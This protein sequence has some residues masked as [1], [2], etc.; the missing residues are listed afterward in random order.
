M[1]KINAFILAAGQGER[2]R[3]ITNHIPK[4]L[5]PILGKPV[6]QRVLENLISIDVNMVGINLHF[7]KELIREWVES[8]GF[9]EN[10]TIFTEEDALG[11]GG[12]LKNA[13]QLLKDS[14]FIL[15]N[16]DI[17]SDIDLEGL[18][19]Y[20][21]ASENLVT[22]AVHDHPEFNNVAIDNAGYLKSVGDPKTSGPGE[23][24]AVAY[25]GVSVYD[26]N[27]LNILPEGQS[28]LVDGWFQAIRGG[29]H[30]GTFDVIGS[31]WND[32]GTPSRYA[33]ALFEMLNN[34]GETV[35]LHTSAKGCGD[36]ETD[37]FIV[38]EDGSYFGSG[39]FLKNSI[40]LPGGRA[41]EDSHYE[42]Y[43]LGNG[44]KINLSEDKMPESNED[45]ILIGTGGSDRNYYRVKND[46]GSAVLMV[47][48]EDDS[49]FNRHIEYSRF[50]KDS[51]VAVPE[52]MGITPNK[53]EALFEDLGDT[54][55][56]SWLKFTRDE[57]TI[58]KLYE[59]TLDIMILLHAA[60]SERVAECPSLKSRVFDYD[61]FRWETGYFLEQF[62]KSVRNLEGKDTSA[63][64]KEFDV[65]AQKADSFLKGVIH[66]DFQSQNIMI[67][68]G[69]IPRVIDFQGARMGPPAYDVASIL[70]DP[71]YRLTDAL[72]ERLLEYYISK[73][74]GS[75][76]E[77][78]K[79]D[80]LNSL[81]YCR[82][83]RHMQA[84]GAYGFLSEKKGKKYFQ[85]HVPE[86]IRL[87]KEDMKVIKY[88]YPV[89]H[90]LVINL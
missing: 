19:S 58:E 13:E 83:Q 74:E 60:A 75:G 31:F 89:L 20:H 42:N 72:R 82:L 30:I 69:R 33:S 34:D 73:M 41:E 29:K 4:P 28:S 84:L 46:G 12:A 15:H 80:L 68:K 79:R 17:V 49:D 18:I 26:P 5:M 77:F 78:K 65:L 40:L 2:L 50:F 32:I 24:R 43:I 48:S 38:A 27:F 70:W 8:S 45:H 47:C 14:P 36:I 88:E 3:P 62:V 53:K 76:S 44:Y 86:G 51:S 7:Q 10:I 90:Q 63:L 64:D 23:V 66:R 21:L 87:L 16:A 1:N 67:T 37:G 55:L 54:S 59:K 25:T 6:L 81:P 22:L 39:A 56:Y 9:F 57:E 11:T 35:Y 61:H 52:L 71:Y 85:K